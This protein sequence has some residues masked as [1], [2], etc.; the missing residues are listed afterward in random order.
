ML[1]WDGRPTLFD[2]TLAIH[3]AWSS[4]SGKG[5]TFH[6]RPIMASVG[7]VERGK[8]CLY[9]GDTLY[10]S[11]TCWNFY[12]RPIMASMG[13][14]ERGKMCLYPEDTLHASNTCLH[15]HSRPAMASVGAVERGKMCLYA[16]DTL[17]ASNICLLLD[18]D[19]TMFQQRLP[20]LYRINGYL[21][22][23]VRQVGS[24][25]D[26]TKQVQLSSTPKLQLQP[27]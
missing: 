17:H 8:M 9:T 1:C 22:Q 26:G 18:D 11:N 27:S 23:Q 12:S 16:G 3:L 4:N 2:R 20:N 13:A 24:V 6:G 7:A 10:A 14:V 21:N 5:T 15:F 25:T 19:L